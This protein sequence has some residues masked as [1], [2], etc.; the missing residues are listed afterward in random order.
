MVPLQLRLKNFLSYGPAVQTIDFEPHHL[1]CLSGKNGHGKSA[2]LDAITW[3]IW[4]QARKVGGTIKSDEHLLRL[5]QSHMLVSLDFRCNG[6]RYRITREF[7]FLSGKKTQTDLHFGIINETSGNCTALTEKTIRA[8]Q[9]KINGTIGLDYDSCINSIF[10]RQGQSNEFS[11]RSPQERKEILATILGL[12]RYEKLRDFAM[13]RLRDLQREHNYH[14]QLKENLTITLRQRDILQTQSDSIAVALRENQQSEDLLRTQKEEEEIELQKLTQV[15]KKKEIITELIVQQKKALSELQEKATIIVSNWSSARR[16][17]R[18]LKLAQKTLNRDELEAEITQKENEVNQYIQTKSELLDLREKIQKIKSLVS[19]KQE[20]EHQQLLTAAVSFAAQ[21]EAQKKQFA[22]HQKQLTELVQ[23]IRGLQEAITTDKK[24]LRPYQI[25]GKS[26]STDLERG[27]E[28]CQL[29]IARGTQI[30]KELDSLMITPEISTLPSCPW[31]DQPLDHKAHQHL[32]IKKEHQ[33]KHQEHQ[34]QRLRKVILA[35]K[36]RIQNLKEIE[37]IEQQQKLKKEQLEAFVQE[38]EKQECEINLLGE[39]NND[40]AEQIVSIEKKQEEFK[41][42]SETFLL[43]HPE[44][45]TLEQK[46]VKMETL[47][48]SLNGCQEQLI[49]LQKQRELFKNEEL[50]N[51][52]RYRIAEYVATFKTLTAQIRGLEKEIKQ[53]NSEI[54]SLNDALGALPACQ[55]QL[56]TIK[57]E[58]IQLAQ[59]REKLLVEKGAIDQQQA[60]CHQKE[61]E[62]DETNTSLQK[63]EQMIEDHQLLIAALGKNGIQALLIENTVPEIEHEAN[64]LLAKLTNNQ[65]HL[66]IE[67]LRDLKGG[68]SKETLDIKIS[69]GLGIRPYELFSGGEAFRIDFA[70]RIAISKLLARRSGTS[71]QTLII[72]EG[73][74]SQ[75]EE[76]LQNIMEALYRIQDNF[77]KIIIV[78]HLPTMKNQFPAHFIVQKG[79]L[80]S[81]I[82]V[83]DCG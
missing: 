16:E 67:S 57:A 33:R 39:Q 19:A 79:P 36:K 43:A 28:Y 15:A 3:A 30:K 75:D 40:I 17:K 59:Q 26:V 1:I 46:C 10:L 8:T 81:T 73:F 54:I 52:I 6:S 21:H 13:E 4:G 66:I 7:T 50:Y 32:R 41:R 42:T 45:K 70:L 55:I 77:E 49:L 25:S 35:L 11:K 80:G 51:Q 12:N 74:G 37:E 62:L 83:S 29:W 64:N 47:C 69:D 9:E 5:G 27:R 44:L 2:L 23:K 63:Y 56:T 60:L 65:S 31:C 53:K 78:S 82:S 20:K 72:D 22:T 58:Q 24:I 71:L 68:G 61:R 76:G 18:T 34:L 14:V 48:T 38:Q